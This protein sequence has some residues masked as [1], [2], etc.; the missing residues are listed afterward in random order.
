MPSASEADIRGMLPCVPND[1]LLIEQNEFAD[2]VAT[3]SSAD[4][5]AAFIK[6]FDVWLHTPGISNCIYPKALD[7]GWR[8]MLKRAPFEMTDDEKD[9]LANGIRAFTFQE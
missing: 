3:L 9:A 4:D 5:L 2:R 8:L 7:G 6:D 1:T